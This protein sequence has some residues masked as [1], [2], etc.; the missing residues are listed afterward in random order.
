M[1]KILIVTAGTALLLIAGLAA[2]VM[3]LMP[4]GERPVPG[5]QWPALSAAPDLPEALRGSDAGM[6]LAPKNTE[7]ADGVN[8]L[9]HGDPAQQNA[10]AISGPMDVTRRLKPEEITYRFLGPGYFG[11][12]T[13]GLYPDGRRVVWANGVNGIYK[14]DS[15]TYDI[16]AHRP[17]DRAGKFTKVWADRITASLDRNNSVWNLPT[18]MK[19][20]SPLM[21]ISG[22]YCVVGKN[23]WFYIANR[24][25]SIR[26]YG[27]AVEGDADSDIVEKGV[28]RLP[29]TAAG[30]T[31]GMNM[32]YDG[33]IVYPTENGYLVAISSDLTR[34]HL[35]RLNHADRENTDSLGV[36][37]GWV[38]NSIA[39]D[40]KGGIYVVSR[41]HL[42]KVVWTGEGFSKDGKDGAWVAEYRN[43]KG[44]GSGAT[45]ALMGFGGED[46]LIAL[47]DGDDR[48]NVTLMWRDDIPEDWTRLP[49]APSRRIAG[50]A[51]VTMGPLNLEKIQ[52]EQTVIVAGYGVLVVNN[53]P[54][55]VP[56][57]MPKDGG[58]NG[59]FIGPLGS[60]PDIQPYGVQKFQWDPVSRKLYSAWVNAD[61][62]SPNGV[63]WVSLGTRQVYFIGARNNEWTLE[64]LNWDTGAETFHYVVGGQK[65]NSEFSGPTLDE[66][67][68][69]FYGAIWGR[70]LLK[71][72]VAGN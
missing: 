52:S 8:A 25:G 70:V 5:R 54:R 27:D 55:N 20:V 32:T 41:N 71:P 56:F 42:H 39:L 4:P 50:L 2:A 24:D 60:H 13:S 29:E 30:P 16:L 61:V 51:P 35:V 33:W 1:R 14:L 3:L 53:Q 57:F 31:V 64:A 46:R 28:F 36:G 10:T 38:R 17:G 48:M 6:L 21:D 34:H 45:P 59:L 43:G 37:Y 12:Y 63:P 69:I 66:K 67:G 40:D 18:A 49:G 72:E 62:S 11:A 65:Y 23:G 22:V 19:A 47:T 7:L 26:A 15:E 44:G 68:R 58:V 9:P